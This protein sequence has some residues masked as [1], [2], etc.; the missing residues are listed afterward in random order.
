MNLFCHAPKGPLWGMNTD[1]RGLFHFH[2][3]ISCRGLHYQALAA[4]VA[5][6]ILLSTAGCEKRI[7][8]KQERFFMN[9]A[10]ENWNKLTPRQKANYYE[11]LERQKE[12]ARK[13]GARDKQRSLQGF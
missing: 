8:M 1:R 13:E 6:V 11:M 9:Y 3:G 7:V 12:R 2:E 10:E 5:F 4:L